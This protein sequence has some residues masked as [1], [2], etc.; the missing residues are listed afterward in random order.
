MSNILL[1]K[2]TRAGEKRVAL[3][4][5]DV[6][7]LISLGHEVVIENDAGVA[8]GFSNDEYQQAG[9]EIRTLAN[10]NSDGF[11]QLFKDT[12][13]I[14]RAKRPNREREIAE[15][16][17]MRSGMKMIGALDPLE[18]NSPHMDEY[19]A[20]G[21]EAI[22][23]DQLDLTADDPRN[24]LT[25]MSKIA[26]RLALKYALEKCQCEAKK[27]VI[28]GYGIVGLASFEEAIEYNLQATVILSN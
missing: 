26:G 12:D 13:I 21:V 20:A 24:I 5:E 10:E 23:I 22:S 7:K 27:A 4:P 16:K 19:K 15:N 9:A 17:A 14:V 8:A 11:T 25:S 18:K 2:E 3:V 6:K 1:V 28:I